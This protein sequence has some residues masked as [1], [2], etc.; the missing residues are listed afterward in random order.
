MFYRFRRPPKP[1][2]TTSFWVLMEHP[3]RPDSIDGVVSDSELSAFLRDGFVLLSSS[4]AVPVLIADE[5]AV[6]VS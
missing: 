6:E 2:P 5:E 3:N 1:Q 4:A